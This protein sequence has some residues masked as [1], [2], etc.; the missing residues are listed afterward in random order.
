MDSLP[1]DLS[2]PTSTH[3]E[4]ATRHLRRLRASEDLLPTVHSSPDDDDDNDAEN[5]EEEPLDN[6]KKGFNPYAFLAE[7][8]EEVRIFVG[9][10]NGSMHLRIGN[11]VVEELRYVHYL[12]LQICGEKSGWVM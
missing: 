9:E 10:C 4:M 12:M 1:Q 7:L 3:F 2:L 5:S 11:N 8:G 6:R